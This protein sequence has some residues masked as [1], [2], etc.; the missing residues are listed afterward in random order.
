M[1]TELVF[2]MP[3][4][5]LKSRTSNC[6]FHT[7]FD[8]RKML[9]ETSSRKKTLTHGTSELAGGKVAAAS[10]HLLCAPGWEGNV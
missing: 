3:F 4:V 5:T 1:Q 6:F 10:V 2:K 9:Q 8:T 7:N